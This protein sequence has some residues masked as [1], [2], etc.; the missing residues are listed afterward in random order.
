MTGVPETGD[1]WAEP[2]RPTAEQLEA[3]RERLVRYRAMKPGTRAAEA[4][5][6]LSGQHY[7]WL[8]WLILNTR[9]GSE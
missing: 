4:H 8:M 3:Y 5:E 1:P 6:L 9:E 2:R 7:A